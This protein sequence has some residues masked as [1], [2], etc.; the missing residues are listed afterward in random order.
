MNSCQSCQAHSTSLAG[1]DAPSD[2]QCNSGFTLEHGSCVP[3]DRGEFGANG[4]CFPCEI[5]KYSYDYN[6]VSCSACF[7]NSSTLDTGSWYIQDCACN[8]GY[9]LSFG[10]G[11][12]GVSCVACLPGSYLNYA[13]DQCLTCE[14]GKY[15]PRLAS[16]S[17][18]SCPP[19]STNPNTGSVSIENCLCLPGFYRLYDECVP[20]QRGTVKA[21][22]SNTLS[23]SP[24]PPGTSSDKLASTQCVACPVN[25]LQPDEGQA[26]CLQCPGNSSST[27]GSTSP[28]DCLCNPGFY[29]DNCTDCQMDTHV[30]CLPCPRGSFKS[31]H[32]HSA[33]TTCPAGTST[34]AAGAIDAGACSPCPRNT[35][36]DEALESAVVECTSCPVHS[37][38]SEGSVSVLDCSCDPGFTGARNMSQCVA[39]GNG[40]YKPFAGNEACIACP[41]GTEGNATDTAHT[42]IFECVSCA[43]NRY[44]ENSVCKDCPTNSFSHAGSTLLH[45]CVCNAGYEGLDVG[46]CSACPSGYF[47]NSTTR[48]VCRQCP[49]GTFSNASAQT[50]CLVC[51]AHSTSMPPATSAADCA[52]SAG[53]SGQDGGVCVACPA[54]SFEREDIC[55]Q[56]SSGQY[57]PAGAGP[58]HVDRCTPCPLHSGSAVGAYGIDACVCEAGYIRQNSSSCVACP[59]GSWCASQD[60]STSCPGNSFSAEAS[61]NIS[62][63]VCSPGFHGSRGV[64]SA[65]G[66]DVFCVGGTTPTTCPANSSTQGL[67]RRTSL[68]DCVCRAG[69]YEDASALCVQCPDD[70]YCAND[71]LIVCPMNSTAVRGSAEIVDCRCHNGL[72]LSN[73][74]CEVCPPTLRCDGGDADPVPCADGAQ[75]AHGVCLCAPGTFC[76]DSDGTALDVAS[77]EHPAA[78]S[79]CPVDSFCSQ[80]LLQPC[81]GNASSPS[82]SQDVDACVCDDGW[83]K[84]TLLC[85]ACPAHHYCSSDHSTPCAAWDLNLVTVGA[86]KSRREHC[87]CRAGWF[88]TS[89]A[90]ACKPCPRDFY[91]L[92]ETSLIM[93]SVVACLENEYTLHEGSTSRAD[94]ICDAGHKMGSDGQVTK[95]LPCAEGE[96]CQNGEILEWSCH[97]S[98][99]TANADHS[100][101]V[102]MS[103]FYEDDTRSCRPCLPGTVKPEIGDH[104]CTPCPADQYSANFTQCLPCPANAVAPVESSVCTCSAPYA[105]GAGDAFCELC[106]ANEHYHFVG[107]YENGQ[108]VSCPA[109]SSS[110]AG[111]HNVSACICDSGFVRSGQ[112]GQ[113]CLPCPENHYEKDHACHPCGSGARS[114]SASPSDDSCVCNASV[115]Q[116]RTWSFDGSPCLGSCEAAI[117]ACFECPPG[118]F[119][120]SVSAAGNTDACDKCA[121]DTYQPS[122]GSLA[123]LHCVHT[124]QTLHQGATTVF[125]CTCRP[126]HEPPYPNQ[127]TSNCSQ[128]ATGHFKRDPGEHSCLSC[129]HGTFADEEGSTAC[130]LCSSESAIAHANT[131]A[132]DASRDVSDC[133]CLPGYTLDGGEC[134]QCVVGSFKHEAGLLAC[135]YC[136]GNVS[137][138]DAFLH[139]TYGSGAAGASSVAHCTPCPHNSGQNPLLVGPDALV[140]NDVTDCLCFG[141]FDSFNAVT[142][143]AQCDSYRGFHRVGYGLGACQQCEASH[144]WVN[145]FQDCVMCSLDDEDPALQAHE[146]AVNS[147]FDNTSWGM[148]QADCV[149]RL[150]YSRLA[151]ECRRCDVGSFRSELAVLSCTPCAVDTFADARGTV[152]CQACPDN[153]FTA[154]PGSTSLGDCLCRAGYAWDGA[155]CVACEPGFFKASD[156]VSPLARPPCEACVSPFFSDQYGSI[157]CTECDLNMHSE[158][159]RD[160]AA[161]CECNAG[162][163]GEPCTVCFW[164]T[165]SA[166]GLPLDQ[167]RECLPCPDGKTTVANASSSI[168]DCV[169][170]PGHGTASPDNASAACSPCG[171]SYYA[172]GF[173]N[174]A[175]AHCGFGGVTFPEQGATTFDACMCNHR[176]GLY[177]ATPDAQ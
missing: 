101:C 58:F 171:N 10:F 74:V 59:A 102:C 116:N 21:G 38:S 167:H 98:K 119:K 92:P 136:G 55:V 96:R 100:K 161:A 175:C 140:M 66:I 128:C 77:C 25:T 126:G 138:Y 71:S 157:A 176:I 69:W 150:G 2:C 137:H 39:C 56:C 4:T 65:C 81:M 5:G 158:A 132:Q 89:H 79:A 82:S 155:A 106:R 162:F 117:E 28:V 8:V 85:E 93:P 152:H 80:N 22:T 148:S 48:E 19:N 46:S 113:V 143:C 3:C 15:Q 78:C 27:P 16:A 172:T 118:F 108:C 134:R 154:Q 153:S 11:E 133:V 61:S 6:A 109:N 41:P 144:Y 50:A 75:I 60:T 43:A 12:S 91:C 54:G 35:Y 53:Y 146:L 32:S 44:E 94:C 124:R 129:V 29:T 26:S 14:T 17:C 103:G 95:C 104:A 36:A 49:A 68:A 64:C 125:N 1:S 164:G 145:T 111:A 47:K 90:D 139:H 169:C 149:C 127:V 142:G 52:C 63:C 33:C 147:R 24:C 83:Y 30:A 120:G 20:C 122:A 13:N 131:T 123:C 18:L 7:G 121:F 141:G 57:Y 76:R 115:C 23:C 166:G 105:R 168:S 99:R 173:I 62:D 31:D 97:V 174:T 42:S 112:V 163:G 159:P 177:E 70:S 160:S 84:R 72:Q 40:K 87:M 165:F 110:V 130:K 107:V 135:N 51:P 67:I 9:H 170:S 45:A 37:T 34:A 151:D 156:D 86:L 114:P 88:R 73:G